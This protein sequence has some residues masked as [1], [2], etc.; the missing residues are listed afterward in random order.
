M[1]PSRF[2][3]KVILWLMAALVLFPL[4]WT[5]LGAFKQTVDLLTPVPKLFFT[6]TLDNIVYVL[7]RQSV[8]QALINSIVVSCASVVIGR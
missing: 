1:T 2:L 8:L 4:L 3:A 5:V 6:P 7:S